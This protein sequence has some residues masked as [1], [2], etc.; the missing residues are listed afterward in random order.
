[1]LAVAIDPVVDIGAEAQERAS[2]VALPSHLDRDERPIINAD[3]DLLHRRNQKMLAVLALQNGGEQSHQR[4]TSDWRPHVEP[5]TIPCD[6]H[7]EIA[8]ERRIPQVHRGQ[9]L[10]GRR[11]FYGRVCRVYD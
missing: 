10:S 2:F 6:S 3:A 8:T 1:M 4:G 5:S 7:V 11:G 9:P